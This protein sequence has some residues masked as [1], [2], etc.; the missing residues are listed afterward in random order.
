MK[1]GSRILPIGILLLCTACANI[2]P[3]QPPSLHLPKP[4]SDVRASR[5]GDH[6]ILTW[7]IP[8]FTTD[9][10]NIR[11]LG[12]TR[13]CRSLEQPLTECSNP[14]GEVAPSTAVEG[15]ATK[16]RAKQNF[17]SYTDALPPN[18]LT[19]DPK[20]YVTYAVEVTN[21]EGRAAGLSNQVRVPL[22]RTLPAPSDFSARVTAQGVELT[23]T[24]EPP[25]PSTSHVSYVYRAY[26]REEA[27]PQ[28]ILIG[29][30]PIGNQRSFS[31][32]DS[33]IE[34]EKT[35]EYHADAV[36]VINEPNEPKVEVPGDNS[37][38][39][40]VY[41]HDVFPPAV[42]S[43]LQAVS[44]GPGQPPFV[45][46]IWAPDTDADLAGYNVY[47]R[48]GRATPVRLNSAL[49]TTPAFRD[50]QVVP[51]KTYFYSISAVDLR[52]NE[53]AKSEEAGEAVP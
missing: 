41:A 29:E 6:V 22:I 44:S 13:I 43:G 9:R 4:P 49:V 40:N 28:Q 25:P 45:D 17:A 52:G 1:P 33:N 23:W 48:E 50:T 39:V 34:W 10:Q 16:P 38:E 26:R 19:Q 14:V 42:P 30:I 7:T 35:Y 18:T 47:R 12:P 11:S 5:R 8:A 46:L 53:S 36:T 31:L 27:N 51:G 3:P 15:Q 20:S 37:P 2:G 24:G 21:S 32:S